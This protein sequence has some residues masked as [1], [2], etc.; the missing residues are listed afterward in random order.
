MKKIL[1]YKVI[2]SLSA[3]GLTTDVQRAITDG[4]QPKGS[5]KVTSSGTK[6]QAMVKYEPESWD[7]PWVCGPD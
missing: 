5:L 2:T 3:S 4:W 7:G 1:E 6:H